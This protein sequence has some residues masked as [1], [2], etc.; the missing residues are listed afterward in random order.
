MPTPPDLNLTTH[1]IPTTHG[2]IHVLD[3]ASSSSPQTTTTT[4]SSP[5]SSPPTPPTLLLLHGNSSSSQIF[6]PLIALSLSPNSPLHHHRILA[7][8]LPGHGQSSDAPPSDDDPEDSL[9]KHYTQ[10]AYADCAL[11]VC[12]ALG[13]R[14]VVVLGW[15]LGG[16][17]AVEMV[18][19][20][21]GTTT[22]GTTTTTQQQRGTV[23]VRGIMITGTPP[24]LGLEQVRRGFTLGEGREEGGEAQH[25]N[26]AATERWTDADFDTF[27][28][29]A[30]RGERAAWIRDAAVRTDGRARRV[31]FDAF[32]A[33]RGCD[34]V[35]VVA[36]GKEKEKGKGGVPCA[37]VNGVDEP[38]V[39]L[40]YLDAIEWGGNLWEGRCHRLP[41][42][43]HAPFWEDPKAFLGYWE[44]F[45]GDCCSETTTGEA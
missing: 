15:S 38:F 13:A 10:P 19:Q 6:L 2:L 45:V 39:N 7:L 32:E 9:D 5:S 16:H 30:A 21:T 33:G 29:E 22:T 35:R 12:A 37:V 40:D 25:V 24:A 34:Q 26:L 3:T 36:G 8:D 20:T 18:A 31:M 11:Q 23:R 17:N 41:G 28:Y 44:R 14:D 1:R 27:P 43:G 42:L 4:T